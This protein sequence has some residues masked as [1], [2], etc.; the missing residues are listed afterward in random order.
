MISKLKM[1]ILKITFS[2]LWLLTLFLPII[3]LAEY[4]FHKGRYLAFNMKF[5]DYDWK[6][7]IKQ[8]LRDIISYWRL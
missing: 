3:Y 7:D 4:F 8:M 2:P 1:L 5:F 6:E